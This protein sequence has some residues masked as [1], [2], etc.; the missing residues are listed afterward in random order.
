VPAKLARSTIRQIAAACARKCG[1]PRPPSRRRRIE[2]YSFVSP[3][4]TVRLS[5]LLWRQGTTAVRLFTTWAPGCRY[6]HPCGPDGFRRRPCRT[7]E[8]RAGVRHLLARCSGDAGEAQGRA[9][10]AHAHGLARGLGLCRRAWGF[11]EDTG[12]KGDD[13]WRPGIS[14]F[15][16]TAGKILLRVVDTSCA[17]GDD[18]CVV[19]HL[20]DLIPEGPAHWEPQFSLAMKAA[21]VSAAAAR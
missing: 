11:K 14:V 21:N 4:G 10:L 6:C 17:P 9:R 7:F 13:G 8:N 20:F 2:D 3:H 19:W 16:K 15:R 5:E 18:F 12:I 1:K